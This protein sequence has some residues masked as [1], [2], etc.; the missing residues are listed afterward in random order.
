MAK[1]QSHAP[2]RLASFAFSLFV[3]KT[4]FSSLFRKIQPTF[5][6]AGVALSKMSTRQFPVIPRPNSPFR[7]PHLQS[8]FST[9]GVNY[10]KAQLENGALPTISSL[11]IFPLL[12]RARKPPIGCAGCLMCPAVNCKMWMAP[13]ALLPAPF[14]AFCRFCLL[15]SDTI[16]RADLANLFAPAHFGESPR[17]FLVEKR[18][19]RRLGQDKN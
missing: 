19:F 1:C 2:Q 18:R 8:V 5:A 15:P 11:H 13:F 10:A 16:G 6:T 7:I 12:P 17:F 4:A 3:A 14:A 9:S